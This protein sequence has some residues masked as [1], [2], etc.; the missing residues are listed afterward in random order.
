MIRSPQQMVG[1]TVWCIPYHI[2][3]L[4]DR[5]LWYKQ[6]ESVHRTRAEKALE[7]VL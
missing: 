5:Y 7:A 3:V 2:L 6:C 4:P 1:V